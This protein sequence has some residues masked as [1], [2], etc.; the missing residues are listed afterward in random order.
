MA[1]KISKS[2]QLIFSARALIFIAVSFLFYLLINYFY[3]KYT[4]INEIQDYLKNANNRI[5]S[6]LAYKNDKWD[7]TA[8][9]ND[10]QTIQD[11]PLYILTIDGFVIDRI[12]PINGFLD[13]S[14]FMFGSSFTTPKTVSILE[15][16]TW[17]LY[18]KKIIRENNI[19]G[20]ILVGDFQPETT[21][22]KNIDDELIKTAD[23]ILSQIK[24]SNSEIDISELD[25][26]RINVRHYVEIIDRFNRSIESVG[27]GIP[28]YID[29]S[30]VANELNENYKTVYDTKSKEPFLVYS[31][32][33]FDMS[34]DP[35]GIVISGYSLKQIFMN[36]RNQLI[37]LT[38]SGLSVIIFIFI[39]LILIFQRNLAFL[40]KNPRAALFG[41]SGKHDEANSK[42]VL[43]VDQNIDGTVVINFQ[44][45]LYKISKPEFDSESDQ[46]IERLM[47]LVQPDTKEIEYDGLKDE[48]LKLSTPLS[49]L[50]TRLGFVGLK[51]D[52]FFPRTSKQRVYFRRYL[53][54]NDLVVMNITTEQIL[55]D[56][57]VSS[58]T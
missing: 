45:K 19:F 15:S 55:T 29:R 39:F 4:A 52:L 11:N 7:T 2:P 51:R 22:L 10:S 24:I 48:Q 54:H 46:L 53:T 34:N 36:L 25:L 8:Y 56:L 14:D 42:M 3:L 32:P 44:G 43:E 50:V 26:K 41:F 12:K 40:I 13:T 5:V 33:I 57:F 23:M 35:I 58:Q 37:F 1:I 9:I 16:E 20:T 17:R 18:S 21:E 49:R 27:S 6:D 28:A 30:Y 38:I 31:K 47:D